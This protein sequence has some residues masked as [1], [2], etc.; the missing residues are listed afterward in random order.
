MEVSMTNSLSDAYRLCG[1]YLQPKHSRVRIT[2]DTWFKFSD[3]TYNFATGVKGV[4]MTLVLGKSSRGKGPLAQNF[5][6][7][8]TTPPRLMDA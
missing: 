4:A 5:R 6:F 2:S 7:N 8:E 1:W 3:L